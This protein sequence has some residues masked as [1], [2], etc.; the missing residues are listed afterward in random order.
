MAALTTHLLTVAEVVAETPD[1][2]SI[3]FD[4]E[5]DY[6]PGQ[7]LTLRVPSER[8]G[9]VARCYSLCSSPHVGDRP[10]V[11]VKR[12]A[13]GYASNWLC[14]NVAAGDTI[15]VLAPSGVF[16]PKHYDDDLL[17]VAG[18]SGITPVMSVLKSALARG[19]RE[20]ALVYANRDEPSVIFA[21]QLRGL[22]ERYP[23]RLTVAHWL[24]SERGLPSVADLA[25]LAAAH[26]DHDAFLCGPQPF[27]KAV[28]EALTELGVPRERRHMERFV[29]LAANPFERAE[30]ARAAAATAA[31]D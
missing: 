8:T 18:G 25:G 14:D 20:V 21:E 12:T 10:Q 17:L 5:L 30:Q 2:C 1:A 26:A 23:G 13:G 27:M 11:T 22:A 19:E 16:G 4:A 15:E 29:S 7:F 31:A 9:S 6:R 28:V 3:A 24:E